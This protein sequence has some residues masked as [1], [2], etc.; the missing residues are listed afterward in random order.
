MATLIRKTMIVF[1]MLAV[2]AAQ[3]L[4]AIASADVMSVLPDSTMETMMVDHSA[5]HASQAMS[6]ESG[7]TN[8]A[9]CAEMTMSCL[10]TTAAAS[11]DAS[12]PCSMNHCVSVM[13]I[14]LQQTS[15]GSKLPMQPVDLLHDNPLSGVVVSLYRPPISH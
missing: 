4:T 5:H 6:H 2:L 15:M 13:G 10:A 8:P 9:C 11:C 12:E 7:Q 3:L 14:N 1:A